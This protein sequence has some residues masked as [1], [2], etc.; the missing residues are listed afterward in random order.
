MDKDRRILRN[1]AVYVENDRILAIGKNESLRKQYRPDLVV[2]GKKRLVMPGFVNVHDH[3][4]THLTRSIGGDLNLFDW[5]DKIILPVITTLNS[6]PSWMYTAAK[7]C[8]MEA[9]KSGITFLF[10]SPQIMGKSI[11]ETI[12]GVDEVGIRGI[13]CRGGWDIDP[14]MYWAY[15]EELYEDPESVGKEMIRLIRT[16]QKKDGLIRIWGDPDMPLQCTSKMYQ[17]LKS[18]ADEYGV[19][20]HTHAAETLSQVQGCIKVTGKRVFDYLYDIGVLGPNVLCSHV[21]WVTERE[22]GIIKKTDTK[23][24]HNPICNEILASG[25]APVPLMLKMGITAGLGIDDGG[26]NCE[27]FFA[28]MKNCGLSHKVNQLDAQVMTAEQIL[29]MATIGGAG[30]V[31]M[32]SEIGSLEVGKKADIIIIDMNS[33]NLTPTL[34]PITNLVYAGQ[35]YNVET[36]IVNGKIVMENRVVKTLN[37]QEIL[38]EAEDVGRELAHVAGLEDLK[39]AGWSGKTL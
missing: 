29:E 11:D 27:D 24:A 33:P 1:A 28:L 8:C 21:V 15:P 13:V 17:V 39:V 4:Y 25:V 14:K 31:G 9:I 5:I 6:N 12:R 18:I 7:H 32:E 34:R 38:N 26:H 2:G 16:Y 3:L 37:E 10:D 22:L 30:A 36:S 35:P 19:G 20:I 23:V